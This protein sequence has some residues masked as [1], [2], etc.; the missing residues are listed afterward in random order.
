MKKQIL[1][2]FVLLGLLTAFLFSCSEKIP[3]ETGKDMPDTTIQTKERE[4]VTTTNQ[5][6]APQTEPLSPPTKAE[7]DW[8]LVLVNYENAL[9]NDFSIELADIDDTRKFDKRAIGAL[10]DMLKAMRKDGR[11]FIWVQSAYR[12]LELQTQLFDA[13]TAPFL[14]QGY[15]REDAERLALKTV[16]RPGTSEHNL[17]LAV[18]FNYVTESFETTAEFDWLCKNAADFGF[19]LRYRKDK[20]EITRVSYEPWHW[21][22]VGVEHAKKINELD[23]CLEEYIEFLQKNS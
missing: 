1:I 12:S 5:T 13:E 20:E 18:D 4:P 6:K 3:N 11:T 23:F 16:N 7:Q 10:N 19:I 14:K 8:R 21:R 22:Y 2:L 15:S 9:P 17:G